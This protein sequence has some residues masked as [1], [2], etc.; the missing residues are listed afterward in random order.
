M[1]LPDTIEIDVHIVIWFLFLM[2]VMEICLYCIDNSAW[3]V[4][5][6]DRQLIAHFVQCY[7]T[8]VEKFIKN[9]SLIRLYT[10]Y[11]MKFCEVRILHKYRP[12]NIDDPPIGDDPYIAIP[13]K[14]LVEHDK[15]EEKNICLEEPEKIVCENF[16]IKPLICSPGYCAYG[17]CQ[18]E[19]DIWQC[20][21]KM[22][23]KYS[24]YLIAWSEV[25]LKKMMPYGGHVIILINYH[26]LSISDP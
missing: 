9:T 7:V 3:L 13:I 4:H 22:P 5:A 24:L 16:W 15:K 25:S 6:G 20:N 11:I 23:M 2:M 19:K 14:H 21:K 18:P 12:A 10:R 1:V 26:Q 8:D 17:N